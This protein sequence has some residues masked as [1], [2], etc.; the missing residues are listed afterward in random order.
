MIISFSVQNFRSIREKVTLDFRATTDKHQQEYFVVD[1]PKPK[2]RILKMAMIYGANASGKSNV[3]L[4]LSF[5]RFIIL[6]DPENKNIELP[7]EAHA[8]DRTS[9]TVFELVFYH[10]GVVY[11]YGIE[12]YLSNSCIKSEALYHYPLGKK[13]IVYTR[14]LTDVSSLTYHYNWIGAEVSTDFKRSMK[15]LIQN[16]SVLASIGSVKNNGPINHARDWFLTTLKP[17]VKPETD[18]YGYVMHQYFF[19]GNPESKTK[20][21]FLNQLRNADFNIDELLPQQHEFSLTEI[22]EFLKK[23]LIRRYEENG[24]TVKQDQ[25]IVN[26]SLELKHGAGISSY[27]LDFG[28]ESLGTQRYFG[29]IGLLF[30]LTQSRLVL[31]DEIESSLH[32]DLIIHF[33]VTF[34]RN[35]S[36][37]QLVFTSHNTAL[38]KEKEILRRDAIWITDRKPDGSTSLTSVSEYPVRKE[39]S[40]DSLYRKGALGGLPNMG[41]TF[42]DVEDETTSE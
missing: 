41:S 16:K 2:M 14:E 8:L 15:E 37:G 32:I 1:I 12:L 20:E 22:P 38:L 42:M 29:F 17:I 35:S 10:N 5:L 7:S 18:L 9:S 33:L 31:I 25:K 40:I 26:V 24:K 4:A 34:L 27:M 30:E 3:L 13:A 36:M 6:N 21:F 28:E 23:E 19:K 39:H 11:E